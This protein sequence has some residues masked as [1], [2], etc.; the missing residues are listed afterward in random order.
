MDD[1]IL[2]IKKIASRLSR[3]Q[4]SIILT[5]VALILWSYSI[6]QA[7][8]EIGKYGLI[9]GFPVL[10][11]ISL[12]ILTIAS[13][14]LWT[15]NENQWKLLLLQLSFLVMSL[16]T[17]HLMV[18]GAPSLYAWSLGALGN[19]EY[20]IRTGQINPSFW[21][22]VQLNWPGNDILQAVVLLLTGNN[23]D[24][25]ADFIPW[26]PII[27]QSLL[28]FPVF[29]FLKN[30]A[31]RIN[32]NY[33][34]AGMWIFYLGSWVGIQNN[35]P[36]VFGTFLAFS[37]LAIL[38]S[39][40]IWKQNTASL[41][42]RMT[43]VIIIIAVATGHFLSSL[44]AFSTSAGSFVSKRLKTAGI[45]LFALL[46]IILW[47]IFGASVYSA[48]K[49]PGML[50]NIL[51]VGQAIQSGISNPIASSESHAAVSAVRIIFS[52]L[53]LFTA[54]IGGL[55]SFKIKNNRY[56]DISVLSISIANVILAAVIGS[57]YSHELLNR[58]FIYLLPALAYFSVKLLH[59]RF[60]L[61]VLSCLLIF[62]LPLSFISQY[63]NQ[64]MD[65]LT[66]GD[67]SGTHFFNEYS[68]NG[69]VESTGPLGL[70]QQ[71]EKYHFLSY[72]DLK[73]TGNQ[74]SIP[75]AYWNIDHREY[76]T[77][78][79]SISSRDKN[80]FEYYVNEPE[81]LPKLQ[82][83]LEMTNYCNLTFINPS[84]RIYCYQY[85]Q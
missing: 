55:V 53:I 29:I 6:T 24:K 71:S 18:G 21:Q 2:T 60:T 57:G 43:A 3:R 5:L 40:G 46:F 68:I 51:S 37:V 16:F 33:V 62:C 73:N 59:Y 41:G 20:I 25:F 82:N 19:P 63:G 50:E 75:T 11:F 56:L 72:D 7:R 9:G 28:F 76:L 4:I 26:L 12:G 39:F 44:V 64:A 15:S 74:V 84:M 8:F 27:W 23:I 69:L 58:F 13:A 81:L 78:Y 54:V 67:M 61:V 47:A 77:N 42:H 35:G 17:A 52:G 10:F 65:N 34:W 70:M 85:H 14:I 31:G 48:G 66:K 80:Y 32:S 30:T 22:L 49:L 45:P 38:S 83:L 79:I 1:L 36:Q